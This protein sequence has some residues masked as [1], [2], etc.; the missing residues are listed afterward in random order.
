MSHFPTLDTPNLFL[1][2]I[3]DTDAQ[4]LL[5]IHGNAQHMKWFGSDPLKDVDGAKGLVKMFAKWREEPTSG[6]RWGI[7][8]RGIPGLIG[9]CGLFRWNRNWR[10]CVLGY[11]ISPLHQGRGYMKEALAAVLAWGFREMELN[12]VEANVH[13]D[14]LASIAV[15]KWLGF[16]EE[17]CL[18]EVGYWAG[19]HHDL[20]LHSLLKREWMNG[21]PTG[22]STRTCTGQQPTI[23]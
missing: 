13:P 14:N 12:R 9:T 1:R 10:T 18:R 3:T 21:S 5:S 20:M 16:A 6:T 7:Q 11:E 17:G 23:S 19:S 4:D 22:Y 8:L 15:L 2:E